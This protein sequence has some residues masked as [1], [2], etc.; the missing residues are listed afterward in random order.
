MGRILAAGKAVVGGIQEASAELP[1]GVVRMAE[2]GRLGRRIPSEDS[3][4]DPIATCSMICLRV[5]RPKK[6]RKYKEMSNNEVLGN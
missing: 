1:A 6:A 2:E 4:Q 3:A 5:S